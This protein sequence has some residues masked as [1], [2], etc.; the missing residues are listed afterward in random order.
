MLNTSTLFD[1][2]KQI[3]IEKPRRYNSYLSEILESKQLS[4]EDVEA[5]RAIQNKFTNNVNEILSLN[6]NEE[7]QFIDLNVKI[8]NANEDYDKIIH[9]Q[10]VDENVL[11]NLRKK[12]SLAKRKE[13]NEVLE[14]I[15]KLD[16]ECNE[17][18]DELVQTSDS[19]REKMKK[20]KMYT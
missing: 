12:I 2:E 14:S 1:V 6:R 3:E 5:L 15:L 4:K 11:S 17:L 7:K 20:L 19:I 16:N 18:L 10:L 13:S 8:A 9:T